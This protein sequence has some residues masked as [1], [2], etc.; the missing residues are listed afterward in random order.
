[1][2]GGSEL[3]SKASFDSK[4]CWNPGHSMILWITAIKHLVRVVKIVFKILFLNDLLISWSV[5]CNVIWKAVYEGS[6]CAQKG[7]WKLVSPRKSQ[8]KSQRASRGKMVWIGCR[9][10]TVADIIWQYL[11][12]CW[13]VMTMTRP[14]FTNRI[15]LS[16]GTAV[17][18]NSAYPPFLSSSP[19]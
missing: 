11:L 4:A 18:V 8:R 2:A 14:W 3:D 16:P 6:V 19:T 9:E 12:Q 7:S 15:S 1:M 10:Y 13:K 17:H 5:T